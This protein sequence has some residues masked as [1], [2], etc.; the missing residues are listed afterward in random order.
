MN[1]LQDPI[2]TRMNELHFEQALELLNQIPIQERSWKD[3]Y[4]TGI[5]LGALYQWTRARAAFEKALSLASTPSDRSEVLLRLGYYDI[6]TS[7]LDSAREKL[8]QAKSSLPESRY[9]ELYFYLALLEYESGRIDQGLSQARA[10]LEFNSKESIK[11]RCEAAALMG[12][13][14][15]AKGELNQAVVSYQQALSLADGYPENWRALRKALVLN[16]LADVYEQF[17]QYD[18]AGTAYQ[19]AWKQMEKVS[20]DQITDLNG[21]RLELLCSMANFQA[22]TDHFEE[23]RSLPEKAEPLVKTLKDPLP[24]YW[25]SRIDYIGGLNELYSEKP[26]VQPFEKLFE[27]WKLQSEF[28]KRS[29]ASSKEYLGKAAYYAAYCYDPALAD[30]ISQED[31]YQQALTEFRKC[32]FKDPDFF[33]YSIASIEN[34]LATLKR[35]S[36]PEEAMKEYHQSLND[37]YRIT[38]AHPDDVEAWLSICAVLLNLMSMLDEDLVFSE[39]HPLLEKFESALEVLERLKDMDR[40][41]QDALDHLLEQ[42]LLR[43]KLP[44]ALMRLY[45]EHRKV[46]LN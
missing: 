7:H 3:E 26:M 30:G 13:L 39:G 31:L 38:D 32:S 1:T 20:D 46:P 14:Y 25:K 36:D 11:S 5:C 27:A 15:S 4:R 17:E 6:Q 34:E 43:K 9:P 23:C 18:E 16:N 41:V 35:E 21:Y 2:Q 8:D 22:L 10:A 33:D 44:R 29:P 45:T 19:N 42:D 37:F 12:D 40:P 28:L 24:L